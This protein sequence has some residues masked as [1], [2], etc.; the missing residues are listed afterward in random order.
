[1]EIINVQN[2]KNYIPQQVK[3][4]KIVIHGTAGGTFSG[5]LQTFIMGQRGVATNF[6]ISQDGTIH[7]LFDQKYFA[8]HAGGNFRTISQTSFGI[9]I[10]NWI[11]LKMKNGQYYT[12]TNKKIHP[13]LVKVTEDW[14]GQ[15]Y[16]Q[17]ITPEQH[18]SLQF[19]LKYLCQKYSIN[20]SFHRE[21][22]P[23]LF[24]TQQFNGILMHSSF[25]PTRLDFE[26]TIIPRISI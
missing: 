15:K 9:Q 26:P 14:R 17:I 20:K 24:N 2:F 5:A 16:W 25:H 8:Y 3:K 6:I 23:S 13:S 4:N 19:L 1:M 22:D 7:R 21:Y 10:V 12:W 11:N 18:K